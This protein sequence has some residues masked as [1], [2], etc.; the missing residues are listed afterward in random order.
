MNSEQDTALDLMEKETIKRKLISRVTN[1]HLSIVILIKSIIIGAM[2][3]IVKNK[4][5]LS[6]TQHLISQLAHVMLP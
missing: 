2:M 4:I 5:S 3:W 1:G 6:I